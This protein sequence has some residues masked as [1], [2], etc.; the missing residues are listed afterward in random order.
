MTDHN[1]LVLPSEFNL[2][3]GIYATSLAHVVAS[4]DMASHAQHL[5]AHPQAQP[6]VAVTSLPPQQSRDCGIS[7]QSVLSHHTLYCTTFFLLSPL[8]YNLH[9]LK[10]TN[11]RMFSS[12]NFYVCVYQNI[13]PTISLEDL[14]MFFPSLPRAPYVTALFIPIILDKLFLFLNSI[15]IE[16]FS[17][18]SSMLFSLPFNICLFERW[19]GRDREE[20]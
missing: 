2:D 19:R 11:M 16:C 18:Y 15:V 14:I 12:V 10:S 4:R 5:Q 20:I 17:F 8:K 9:V 3:L 1:A 6:A 13:G 7:R